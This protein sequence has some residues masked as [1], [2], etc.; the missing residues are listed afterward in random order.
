MTIGEMP[1]QERITVI[2]TASFRFVMKSANHPGTTDAP[3]SVTD[4]TISPIAT[5]TDYR[6]TTVILIR[7][8]EYPSVNGSLLK[9]LAEGKGVLLYAQIC[10]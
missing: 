7:S 9:S 4:R 5:S 3:R 10:W 8:N 2:S 6:I 1:D